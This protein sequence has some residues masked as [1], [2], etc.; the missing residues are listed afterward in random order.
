MRSCFETFL[1]NLYN[2][3]GFWMVESPTRSTEPDLDISCERGG[4]LL[5]RRCEA[6]IDVAPRCGE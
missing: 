4:V 5:L 3:T 2:P 1:E 6:S